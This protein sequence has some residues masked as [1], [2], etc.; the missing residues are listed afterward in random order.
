MPLQY[1]RSKENP[2]SRLARSINEIEA[3]SPTILYKAGKDNQ[4]ADVLPRMNYASEEMA[5]ENAFLEPD[6]LYAA[7]DKLPPLIRAD[8]PLLYLSRDKVN[9]DEINNVLNK[10]Q[11]IFSVLSNR[12]YRHARLPNDDQV[13]NVPYL[14][15]EDRADTLSKYHELLGHAGIKTTLYYMLARF[16]W[17]SIKQDIIDC[18]KLCPACQL[19]S[20]K[21]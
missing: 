16:W 4:I 17:P 13:H 15:F 19:N 9:S 5:P 8:W 7:W 18:W 2:P 10:K 6:M 11:N 20:R 14:P 12:I 1:F 21:G 3:M